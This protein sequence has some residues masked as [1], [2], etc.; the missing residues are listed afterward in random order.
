[1]GQKLGKGCYVAEAQPFVN[2]SGRA[3]ELLWSAF[4]DIAAG[5]GLNAAEW[6]A[7]C[8]TLDAELGEPRLKLSKQ[9]AALFAVLDDDQN[10]LVDAIE[11]L[12]AL[13][14]AS[15]LSAGS[16]LE[17]IFACY[18]FDGRRLLTVDEIA[19]ALTGAVVEACKL[20]NEVFTSTPLVR[21]N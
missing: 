7:I 3:L 14:A 6:Q 20:I 17:Y 15:G 19:L 11:A 9:A 12:S 2:L 18:D 21:G 4:N 10:G 16:A 8:Q 13:A 1:M 5:F